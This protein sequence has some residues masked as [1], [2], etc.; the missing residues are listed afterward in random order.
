[1][2]SDISQEVRS[3]VTF[4][5]AMKPA[6]VVHRKP[7]THGPDMTLAISVNDGLSK[8]EIES[9]EPIMAKYRPMKSY[10]HA[11]INSGEAVSNCKPTTNFEPNVHYRMIRITDGQ[12]RITKEVAARLDRIETTHR[13]GNLVEAKKE[14]DEFH[15]YL[16]EQRAA[17]LGEFRGIQFNGA[18]ASYGVGRVNADDD[19]SG[20]VIF[21]IIEIF[22]A[23]Q[24]REVE[25]A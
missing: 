15:Q 18:V 4:A 12:Y 3:F 10:L 24:A 22:I 23:F 9:L 5:L 13:G 19:C 2:L 8:P 14:Y 16:S 20:A 17:M 11:V 21:V 7:D 6:L 25:A 1:M